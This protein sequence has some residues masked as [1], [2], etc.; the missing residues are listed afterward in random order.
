MKLFRRVLAALAMALVAAG[1]IRAK[2]KGGTP[3]QHG[4]WRRLEL[5]D[6]P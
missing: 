3:P 2:G 1:A 4:G 5:P 6:A